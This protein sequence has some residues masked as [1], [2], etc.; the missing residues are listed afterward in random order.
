MTQL[1][2]CAVELHSR[3]R[4]WCRSR[5][6][7]ALSTVLHLLQ[8]LNATAVAAVIVIRDRLVVIVTVRILLVRH[9]ARHPSHCR[10]DSPKKSPCCQVRHGV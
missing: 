2:Y 7:C 10:F 5:H 6:L 8:A 3:Q 9:L 4:T 1:N